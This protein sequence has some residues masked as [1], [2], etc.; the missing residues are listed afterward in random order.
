MIS[1][2][3]DTVILAAA[4]FLTGSI[5]VG[6]LIA[7]SRGVNIR[8]VGSGNIGATN[9]LR[10]IGTGWGIF[11]GI[12]DA[13]KGAVPAFL[14]VLFT[15]LPGI[16]GA[17][18]I[19]GHIFSPWLGFKGGKGVAT[20]LGVFLVLAPIPALTAV[21]IWIVLFLSVGY[22]SVA[23]VFSLAS[24][25]VFIFLWA[26]LHPEISVLAAAAGCALIVAWTHRGNFIR[27]AAGRE[28]QAKL[29]RRIWKR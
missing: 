22:V 1:P 25:P 17:A 4:G 2:A 27:L 23:S 7:R 24:L 6:F 20:T 21:F 9:A 15:P 10:A 12:L 3:W 11:V 26:R 18:A 29:W 16:V 14:A 5:P 13:L 19:V 28:T 8:Q